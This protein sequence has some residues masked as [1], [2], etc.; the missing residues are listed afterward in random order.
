MVMIEYPVERLRHRHPLRCYSKLDHSH[1]FH[2]PNHIRILHLKGT[3]KPA[4]ASVFVKVVE[5]PGQH[6][7]NPRH[8]CEYLVSTVNSDFSHPT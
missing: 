1:G 6:Y 4:E 5:A 3:S 8:C 7:E 2:S